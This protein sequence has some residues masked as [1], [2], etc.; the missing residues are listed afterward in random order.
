M[1]KQFVLSKN[2]RNDWFYVISNAY[3]QV[4]QNWLKASAI[5]FGLG[6]LLFYYYCNSES[7][8]CY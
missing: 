6:F 2:Y 4:G 3:E 1:N 7:F 8:V 5:C